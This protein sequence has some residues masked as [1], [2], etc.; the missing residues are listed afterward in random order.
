MGEY[1][2]ETQSVDLAGNGD[3]TMP[4]KVTI[5]RP[6]TDATG[7]SATGNVNGKTITLHGN[8]VV[9]DSGQAPEAGP[10]REEYQKGG[11]S[12]MTCDE[13]AVDGK[14]L[15]YKASGHVHYSQG[16]RD[17]TA[18]TAILDR[19]QH[20]L[21]LEGNVRGKEEDGTQLRARTVDYDTTSKDYLINGDPMT[22]IHPIPSP[23]PGAPHPSPSPGKAKH[24]LL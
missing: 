1:T 5:A 10:K 23:S 21:H 18:E 24:R 4:A 11:P 6:G 7:D 9:H 2:L 15:V 19:G 3:F 17:L 20:K 16:N 14:S 22:V 8:V 13:L 12:T